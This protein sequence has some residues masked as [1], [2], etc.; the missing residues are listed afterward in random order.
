MTPTRIPAALAHEALTHPD[1]D[2]ALRLQQA[3]GDEYELGELL[4]RGGFADVYL[5]WDRRLK[6]EVAVKTV[7]SD[8][9]LSPA[10]LERFRREAEAMAQLRHPHVIPV[11]AVG[12]RAG[13]AYFI[14]PRISGETLASALGREGRWSFSE[15]VRVLRE[16]AGALAE[17]H[18]HGI[19]HRDV[20]PENIML[21]GPERRVVVMDFGIAKTVDEAVSDLTGT[22]VLV[23]SPQ[24]MSPEQAT[25]D[26]SIDHLSDQYSL[27][28]VGY[29]M[30]TGRLPFDE[31]SVR[32]LLY[33]QATATVTPL[34]ELRLDIPASLARII[35]RALEK[36]PGKRFE[37]MEAFTE[38]LAGIATEVAGEFRIVR[39]IPPMSERW[40]NAR[41]ELSGN[42]RRLVIAATVALVAFVFAYVNSESAIVR[43]VAGSRDESI[44]AARAYL[45]SRALDNRDFAEGRWLLLND[46]A[47]AYMQT[48][49]GRDSADALI[50]AGYPVLSWQIRRFTPPDLWTVSFSMGQHLESVTRVL[51]DTSPRATVSADSARVLAEAMLRQH[52]FVPAELALLRQSENQRPNR[53]DRTFTWSVPALDISR[54]ADTAK[55]ELTIEMAGDETVGFR[56]ALVV[57]ATF[58][59]G[60]SRATHSAITGLGMLFLVAVIVYA[61]VTTTRRAINRDSLQ[62]ASAVRWGVAACVFLLAGYYIPDILNSSVPSSPGVSRLSATAGGLTASILELSIIWIL[63]T[64]TFVAAESLAYEKRPDIMFGLTEVGSGRFAIPEMIPAAITGYT[65]GAAALAVLYLYLALAR[66][67]LGLPFTASVE[68]ILAF[69]GLPLLGVPGP[70]GPIVGTSVVALIVANSWRRQWRWVFAIAAIVGLATFRNPDSAAWEELVVARTVLLL[71][72]LWFISRHGALATLIALFVVFGTVRAA[73]LL[74]AG[75]PF[76]ITGVAAVALLLV[77]AALAALAYRQRPEAK[78]TW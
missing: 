65:A 62:W 45:T 12:E 39:R 6:R 22:G 72:A 49:V 71:A 46:K 3:L 10:V 1:S 7:R 58:Q 26:K 56:R 44:Y 59:P 70:T 77:P 42:P 61:L 66:N 17:A 23:G 67:W 63:V 40:A 68:D 36:D 74:W 27:G 55:Y 18:R 53:R 20:K 11:Y 5:A 47:Y 8:L 30:L 51:A 13:I 69:E 78:K 54:A 57:P 50:R 28:I 2:V 14:M 21:D 32:R 60:L 52:G 73:D 16:A 64:F 4:G 19:I 76:T 37:S 43:E 48:A 38:S 25:G 15:T 34:R 33:Q 75:G 24:Y 41:L 29:R 31:D 9:A 35:E